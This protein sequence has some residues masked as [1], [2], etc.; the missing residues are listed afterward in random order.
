MFFAAGGGE[1]GVVGLKCCMDMCGMDGRSRTMWSPRGRQIV[2]WKWFSPSAVA[3]CSLDA[4][5]L[6]KYLKCGDDNRVYGIES[7]CML[8]K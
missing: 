8:I 2:V 6:M 1:Y 4:R 5:V 3:L 7:K